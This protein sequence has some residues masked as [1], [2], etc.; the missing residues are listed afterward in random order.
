MNPDLFTAAVAGISTLVGILAS[1]SLTM[2]RIKQLEI[3]VDKHNTIIERMTKAEFKIESI[4]DH[5]KE[6]R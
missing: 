4:E 3:K 6:W 5:M 1:N 2:Y